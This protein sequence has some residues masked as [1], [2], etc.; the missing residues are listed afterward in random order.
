VTRWAKTL[1]DMAD[2]PHEY[3]KQ[4]MAA[5]TALPSFTSKLLGDSDVDSA[6]EFNIKWSAASLYSGG[7]DTTVSAI[8]SFFLAMSLYPEVQRKAQA[9]I[10][11]VV[12]NDR[13]PTFTDRE[14]LPFI[15]ALVLEVQRWNPVTPLGVPHRVIEDDVYDDYLIPKGSIVVANIWKMTH[16]PQV[17][18][19]PYEFNPDRFMGPNPEKDPRDVC[20]GF[21]RRICPG[22]NLADASVFISCAMSLAVFDV[23][24]SVDDSGRVI[25]PI[26]EYTDGTISHPKPF[27]CSIKP[28]SEKSEALIHAANA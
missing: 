13:L 18:S 25:E 2:I 11:A 24:K 15:E 4:Q 1:S 17:Y 12:G 16:D 14:H 3:V 21:G 6:A 20:F 27:S 9:E 23:S 10:D 5:G 28:R 8:N 7:A 19:N 26:V 22:L